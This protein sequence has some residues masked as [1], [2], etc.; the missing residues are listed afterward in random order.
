MCIRDSLHAAQE[1]DLHGGIAF[2]IHTGK[3]ILGIMEFLTYERLRPSSSRL[4]RASELGAMITQ[5]LHRKDLERQLR[6]AQKMEA[7][8]RMALSLIHI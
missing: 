8:G 3:E 7:L 1:A 4:E 5:F 6:Q 2:P